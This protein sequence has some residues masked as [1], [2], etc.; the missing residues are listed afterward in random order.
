M[1][2]E[3]YNEEDG[4]VS[5]SVDSEKHQKILDHLR[6]KKLRVNGHFSG[7]K[8]SEIFVAATIERVNDALKDFYG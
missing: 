1:R 3:N 6:S 8:L 4:N 2:I 7:G 5:F